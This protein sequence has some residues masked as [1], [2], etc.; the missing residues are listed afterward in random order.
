MPESVERDGENRIFRF[1]APVTVRSLVLPGIDKWNSS[2]AYEPPWMRVALDVMTARGWKEVVRTPLPTTNWR[3]YVETFTLAC[4]EES[5]YEW[6]FRFEHDLP[7]RNYCE[8]RLSSAPRMTD[9]E[10]RSARTLRSLPKNA[11][12]QQGADCFVDPAKIVDLTSRREWTVPAGRW[13]VVRFGHVNSK[14]VNAPAPKEATGWE[15]DKLDPAGI[16]AHFRGFIGRLN[17]GPLKGRMRAIIVDSWECFCQTWTPKMETYFREANGYGL[18]RWLPALF[19]WIVGSPDVTERFLT[20]WRRTNGNL[21]TRNYYGRMAELAHEAGLEVYYETAFGDIVHGDLM[22]YWKFADAPMCEFWYPHKDRLA[23]GCC[24]YQFKPI[25]PCASA[26]HIYGK[27]RVAA[28]AFT[29]SGIHWDERFMLPATRVALKRLSDA[30]GKVVFGGKDALVR[31]LAAIR[32]DVAT[33]PV[34]GDDPSEDFMWIHRKVEGLDRYFVAAGTN[35]WR[36]RVT[37]RAKGEASVL[38][39]VSLERTTW[40]NGDELEIPPSRSVFVEFGEEGRV[41][42]QPSER[43]TRTSAPPPT[44]CKLRGWTLS[45]P[46]GWGAPEK[47]ALEKPVSWT[48]IPGFSQEARAFSGTV[49]YETVFECSADDSCLELDLGRVESVAKVFVN[50]R[51]VRTLWCEP[52]RCRLDGFVRDGVN[53]LRIE[54]TNTWHNRVVYDLGQ[55]EEHRKTWIIYKPRY[56]PAPTDP[57]VP[58]GLLG[59]VRMVR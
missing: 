42:A 15:C 11:P 51:P 25:R 31:A 23:G 53:H 12:P 41:S 29:G 26:A 14:R 18:R 28:E 24:W 59:P 37:F 43:R 40:R 50:G 3:D 17:E 6:R 21:I 52:Y 10:G 1:A 5:G 39:P 35:G 48:D 57:F 19:G 54:V 47:V 27:K 58:S 46:L 13:T 56:N 32:K 7:I 49:A 22:E 34:L 36:G 55:P 20:D 8:P 4:G 33:C 9:W 30:G 38:D 45:F 16:E 44:S 2:H